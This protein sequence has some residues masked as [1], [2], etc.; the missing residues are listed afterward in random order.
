MA[1]TQSIFKRSMGKREA[2]PQCGRAKIR[3]LSVEESTRLINAYSP[4]FRPL[5][6]A[7]LLTGCRYGELIR[8]A[9]Q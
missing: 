2:I 6:T 7:E 1:G 9:L 3:Y 4:E 8:N 5:I